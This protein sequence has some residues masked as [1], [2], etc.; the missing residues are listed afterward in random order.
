MK[1]LC[2]SPHTDDVELSAGGYVKR[3]VEEGHAV[4]V[5][6]F[7]PCYAS[8]P[9]GFSMNVTRK[10]SRAAMDIL[11]VQ[12]VLM[13]DFAVRHFPAHRQAI[14]EILVNQRRVFN[15]DMVLMPS[16]RDLHQDHEVV[17]REGLRAFR[18]RTVL[19]YDSPRNMS[20]PFEGAC[21]V[22]V[23]RDQMSAKLAAAECYAS[24]R[25]R[26][27]VKDVIEAQARVRGRQVNMT[28]AEAFEV[29]RWTMPS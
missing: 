15:P 3:L 7:S 24:Q 28:Y 20:L 26:N 23:T 22:Q 8:I 27:P 19:G 2:L 9:T 10:E 17:A 21:Y 13:L 25:R 12:D 29:V 6:V 14:L 18:D 1:I 16:T 5:L 11:G 4:R